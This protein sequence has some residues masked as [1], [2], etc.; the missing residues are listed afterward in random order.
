[1]RQ[2]AIRLA[3]IVLVGGLI[4]TWGDPTLGQA[5]ATTGV[6]EGT[7]MSTGGQVIP[8]AAVSLVSV[9]GDFNRSLKTDARGRFRAESL[10]RGSYRVNVSL[11]GF[12]TEQR[13]AV[14]LDPGDT[15]MLR[16]KLSP[17]PS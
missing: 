14:E 6:I 12:Q 17:A 3:A 2:S 11:R 10:P 4:W 13:D 9:R 1:M 16:F 15:V 5:Q 8:G 7:V